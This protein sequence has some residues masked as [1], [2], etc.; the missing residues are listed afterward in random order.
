LRLALAFALRS[1]RLAKHRLELSEKTR[2][3]IADQ[4]VNYLIHDGRSP[5]LL[6]ETKLRPLADGSTDQREISEELRLSSTTCS[7]LWN[8]V[9]FRKKTG[10]ISHTGAL[11]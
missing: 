3:R 10:T 8:N 5:E 7:A 9:P 1:V 6:E 4:A 2:Y 11:V